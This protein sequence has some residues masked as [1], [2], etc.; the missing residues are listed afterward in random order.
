MTCRCGVYLCYICRKVLP[1][2]QPYKHF[3]QVFNCKHKKCGT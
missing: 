1:K 2:V 3:C